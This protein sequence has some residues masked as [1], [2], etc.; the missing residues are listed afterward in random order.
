MIKKPA[1]YLITAILLCHVLSFFIPDIISITCLENRAF[2]CTSEEFFALVSELNA[3]KR[4]QEE[5][6]W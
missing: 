3:N 2:A 5:K 1:S 6:K 4:A